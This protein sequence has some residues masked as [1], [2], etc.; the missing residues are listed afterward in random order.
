MARVVIIGA[1]LT[2]LSAAY[3]LEQSGFFDYEIFEKESEPGGLLRS[4]SHD[5][6]TFDY[7]GHIL[8]VNDPYFGWFLESI[9]G[10]SSLYKHQRRA[11]ILSHRGYTAYP[12][13]ENLGGLPPAIAKQCILDYIKRPLSQSKPK[14]FLEW[15]Q[16]HFGRGISKHFLIPYNEKI[17]CKNLNEIMSSW[18]GRFVPKT[19]LKKLLQGTINV[20]TS[21]QSGYNPTF[22]YPVN[23]GIQTLI[24]KLKSRLKNSIKTNHKAVEVNQTKKVVTFE[25]GEKATYSKLISTAPLPTFL[26]TLSPKAFAIAEKKLTAT[27]TLCL[28]LGFNIPQLIKAHWVYVPEKEYQFH[29]FGTWSNFSPS[30]APAKHSSVYLEISFNKNTTTKDKLKTLAD[31]AIESFL[32]LFNLSEQNIATRKDLVIPTSYVVYDLWREKNITKI[33]NQLNVYNIYSEGRFGAWKYSSMQEAVLDGKNVAEK[34]LAELVAT[35]QR[36]HGTMASV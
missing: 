10:Q 35:A 9:L 3:H 1:G 17:T 15:S 24:S 30:M 6:F 20:S 31:T 5:G 16:H 29:R 34:I 33:H 21:S 19:S 23:G 18:T 26:K 27:S 25:N 2:G 7:S 4:I 36:Q 8:H 14:T 28:N 13:Q 12:F 11:F 32:K 22:F